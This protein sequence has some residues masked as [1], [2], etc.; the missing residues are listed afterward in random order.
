MKSDN[1]TVVN[2]SL[3]A[4]GARFSDNKPQ[5]PAVYSEAGFN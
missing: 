5:R 4:G 1:Y 3:L 2:P